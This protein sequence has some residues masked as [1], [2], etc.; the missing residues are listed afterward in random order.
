MAE[1][2]SSEI[3]ICNQALLLLGAVT[4]NDFTESSDMARLCSNLYAPSRNAV[5]RLHPWN[6]A[7]T[8]VQL[9]PEAAAPAFGFGYSFVIPPDCERILEVSEDTYKIERRKILCDSS[10]LNLKYIFRNTAVTEY[11]SLFIDALAA[12]LAFKMAYPITKSNETK[13]VMFDTFKSIFPMAKNID[14]QE[15]PQDTFGDFPF[16][17]ARSK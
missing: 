11:D 2:V 16:I 15:E 13:K 8:R 10:V 7:V 12:Y 1:V 3:E 6:F 17:D 4:I 5:L 9:A 14:G